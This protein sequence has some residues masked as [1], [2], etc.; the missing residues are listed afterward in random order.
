[1]LVE[2]R[3]VL[4]EAMECLAALQRQV[5]YYLF[6]Q[7][8]TQSEVATRLGVSQRHVSRLLGAAL[9]RLAGPL[10]DAGMEPPS[11]AAS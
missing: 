8:L 10:R 11:V 3:I 5:V 6:Y 9:R 1:M 7:E 2:D 4:L